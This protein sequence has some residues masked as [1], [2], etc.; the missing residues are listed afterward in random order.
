M[1]LFRGRYRYRT[2]QFGQLLEVRVRYPFIPTRIV[3]QQIFIEDLFEMRNGEDGE[4]LGPPLFYATH[5]Q[6]AT[7]MDDHIIK[8]IFFMPA[9]HMIMLAD[10]RYYPPMRGL[11]DASDLWAMLKSKPAPITGQ[12]EEFVITKN[13]DSENGT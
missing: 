3:L 4:K 11:A 6:D 12:V 7:H 1:I 9:P 2:R 5:S 13:E 10:F 8:E